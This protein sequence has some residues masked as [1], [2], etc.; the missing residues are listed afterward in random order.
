M[1]LTA[2]AKRVCETPSKQRNARTPRFIPSCSPTKKNTEIT[3]A[4]AAAIWEVAD[5]GDILKNRDPT[6]KKFSSR[7]REKRAAASLKFPRS[8]RSTR[9]IPRLTRNYETSTPWV[10]LLIKRMP[11]RDI[12]RFIS[13]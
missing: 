5:I 9:F 10:T 1:E 4:M 12:T 11:L 8:R 6:E 7:C 3:E 2:E 13:Q